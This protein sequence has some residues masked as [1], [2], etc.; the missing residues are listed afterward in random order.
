S[1]VVTQR[2]REL[3]IRN[4]IGAT[5]ENIRWLIL[6]DPGSV[7]GVGIAVGHG[8]AFTLSCVVI[9][10]L[11]GIKPTELLPTA[12][13]VRST[14]AKSVP[15][16]TERLK[17]HARSSGRQLYR[18]QTCAGSTGPASRSSCLRNS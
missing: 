14:S 15:R 4:A 3:G 1:C 16:A 10:L 7:L 11:F 6:S 18:R 2:T 9:G 17:G 8:T 13:A 5:P 12:F